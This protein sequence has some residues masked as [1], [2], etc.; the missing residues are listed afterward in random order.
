VPANERQAADTAYSKRR[1]WLRKDGL[2]LMKREYYDRQ[3]RL[4]KV[5]TMR[6]L[7]NVKGT[8][9]RSGEYEMHDVQNGTKTL[10]VIE[11]RAIE[12]GLT[13]DFFSEAELTRGGS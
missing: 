2:V 8:V 10:V 6:R 9:W 12:K 3:G 1:R 4:E 13:D 11:K 7:V 5:E